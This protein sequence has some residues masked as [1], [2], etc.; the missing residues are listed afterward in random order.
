MDG[1]QDGEEENIILESGENTIDSQGNGD[2]NAGGDEGDDNISNPDYGEDT[3][4]D[5]TA[6]NF[7]PNVIKLCGGERLNFYLMGA[8]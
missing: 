4:L 8:G 2:D 7:F 6:E 1:D 5:L 3:I